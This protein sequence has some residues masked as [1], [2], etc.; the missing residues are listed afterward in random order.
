MKAPS[1][2]RHGTPDATETKKS[3]WKLRIFVPLIIMLIVMVGGIL[4]NLESD[5]SEFAETE[6]MAYETY[7]KYAQ[8]LDAMT[9][10]N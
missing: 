3:D 9:R 5:R 10:E 8:K 4:L 6:K 2:V 7:K 1:I